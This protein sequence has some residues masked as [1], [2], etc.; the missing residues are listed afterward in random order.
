MDTVTVLICACGHSATKTFVRTGSQVEKHDFNAGK[1]FTSKVYPVTGIHELS[2]VLTIVEPIHTALLLRGE[3]QHGLDTS[4]PHQ[5]TKKGPIN[6]LTPVQGHRYAMIDIDKLVLPA[7]LTLTKQMLPSVIDYVIG[8]LPAEFRNA[9]F[10]WQLPSHQ[11]ALTKEN[12]MSTGKIRI[13]GDKVICTI[14]PADPRRQ[15]K[16]TIYFSSHL[17]DFLQETE[18]DVH[19]WAERQREHIQAG[20]L[21]VKHPLSAKI[22]RGEKPTQRAIGDVIRAYGTTLLLDSLDDF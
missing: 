7:G 8:Q 4:R 15:N 5:R 16:W 2:A 11:I 3:P 17:Y 13:K 21:P 14:E 18:G 22:K 12:H 6:Y 20:T 10:H 19:L 9:S 1:W